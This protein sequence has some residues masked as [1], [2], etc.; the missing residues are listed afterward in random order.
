MRADPSAGKPSATPTPADPLDQLLPESVLAS[1][2][3]AAL[4]W[5]R[6]LLS[7]GESVAGGTQ[8]HT[9]AKAC[10]DNG[11]LPRKSQEKMS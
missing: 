11:L 2:D 7:R 8:S 4:R 6:R 10:K 5:L 9:V 3:A 1:G